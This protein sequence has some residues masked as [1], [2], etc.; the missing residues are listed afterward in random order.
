MPL[1]KL[2]YLK[3]SLQLKNLLFFNLLFV[4]YFKSN[5]TLLLFNFNKNPLKVIKY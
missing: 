1:W 2:K 4:L 3:I 5:Y